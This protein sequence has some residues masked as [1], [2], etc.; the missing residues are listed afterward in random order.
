MQNE[1]SWDENMICD[2]AEYNILVEDHWKCLENYLK[3]LLL[4]KL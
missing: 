3:T 1:M 2:V 4:Y